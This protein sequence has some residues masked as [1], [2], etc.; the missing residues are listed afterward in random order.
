MSA[1]AQAGPVFG[2]N[3]N[4]GQYDVCYRDPEQFIV[5][6][7]G[8]VGCIYIDP[9]SLEKI[10]G[11]GHNYYRSI[12]SYKLHSEAVFGEVYFQPLSTLSITAGMRFSNDIKTSTPYPT[13]TLLSGGLFF[14]GGTVDGGYPAL[15]DVK[16]DFPALTGRLVLAWSPTPAS[17]ARLFWA[18]KTSCIRLP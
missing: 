15:P 13:Q 16:Q 5:T 18:K 12:N 2:N 3:S 9:N 17:R 7:T 8:D 11:Q 6:P 1:L 14:G 4:R 10:N